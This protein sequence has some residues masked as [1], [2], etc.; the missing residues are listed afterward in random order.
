MC[1]WFTTKPVFFLWWGV[2]NASP[3]PQAGGPPL[4]RCPRL[5][6]QYICSYSP[7]WRWFLHPQPEDVPC[8]GDRNTLI[9]E[10]TDI[11]W[12]KYL[13]YTW[14]RLCLFLFTG[15]MFHH[16][17][18][19]DN[20]AQWLRTNPVQLPL[21]FQSCLSLLSFHVLS[22]FGVIFFLTPCSYLLSLPVGHFSFMFILKFSAGW[23]LYSYLNH[24]HTVSWLFVHTSSKG[25]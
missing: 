15:I 9:M 11:R 22:I 23:Y 14:R 4:F 5:L 16:C 8:L 19:L 20:P 6:I 21:S 2:F 18:A 13:W 1:S 7:Y 24:V 10:V 17:L 3:K 25:F 12:I